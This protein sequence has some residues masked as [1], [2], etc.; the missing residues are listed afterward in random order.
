MI[1]T[2]EK[3]M[4]AHAKD[5]FITRPATLRDVRSLIRAY[6]NLSADD[7]TRFSLGIFAIRNF[8]TFFTRFVWIISVFPL[9][10]EV[11]SKMYL[12][13][14]FSFVVER[15]DQKRIIGFSYLL[16]KRNFKSGYLCPPKIAYYGVVVLYPYKRLGAG[17]GMTLYALEFGRR[18]NLKEICVRVALDNV[19]SFSL[20]LKCSF[21]VFQLLEN[22]RVIMKYVL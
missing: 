6:S 5:H 1:N 22:N 4:R 7:R 9:A 17:E 20:F 13:Y 12:P 8:K 2:L 16:I 21:K 18:K 10:R 3:W 15:Y 11:L 14:F 19:A